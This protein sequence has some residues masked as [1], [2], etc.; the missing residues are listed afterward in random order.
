[1]ASY[2]K[3]L[4]TFGDDRKGYSYASNEQTEKILETTPVKASGATKSTPKATTKNTSKDTSIQ[5]ET[6][7]LARLYNYDTNSATQRLAGLRSKLASYKSSNV[8]AMAFGG[9][10]STIG[11]S[12][13]KLKGYQSEIDTLTKELN[14]AKAVQSQ[15]KAYEDEDRLSKYDITAAEKRLADMQK[16]YS[17]TAQTGTAA[18][19]SATKTAEDKKLKKQIEELSKEIEQARGVQYDKK[20]TYVLEGLKKSDR[21]AWSKVNRLASD[22]MAEENQALSTRKSRSEL[23]AMG[24]KD[25]DIDQL[26]DYRRRQIDKERYMQAV[27]RAQELANENGFLASAETVGMGVVSGLGALDI[28]EQNLAKDI[29]GDKTPINYYTGSMAVAAAR[30]AARGQVASNIYNNASNTTLGEV[31]SFLYQTGMSMA[32]SAVNMLTTSAVG[33]AAGAGSAAA[34]IAENLGLAIMGGSAAS[35]SIMAAKARGLSDHQ[36]LALGLI[37]GAAEI[38]TEKVS[39]EAFLDTA[40]RGNKSA[41]K[42]LCKNIIAEGS[43]EVA[44]DFINLFSDIIISRDKSEW[45]QSV[46]NYEDLGYDKNLAFSQAVSDQAK[47]MGVSFL[48]GALSGGVMGA[49]GLVIN[50]IQN[51]QLRVTLTAA[52]LADEDTRT[53]KLSQMVAEKLAEGDN[54]K[55]GQEQLENM[56]SALS[57]AMNQELSAQERSDLTKTAKSQIKAQKQF[58]KAAKQVSKSTKTSAEA[59]E[60]NTVTETETAAETVEAAEEQPTTVQTE[61]SEKSTKAKAAAKAKVEADPPLIVAAIKAPAGPNGAV[62]DKQ[63]NAIISSKA[64]VEALGLEYGTTKSLKGMNPAQSKK[65]VRNALKNYT[66]TETAAEA[67]AKAEG[68]NNATVDN[69]SEN[70]DNEEYENF[71]RRYRSQVNAE[72]TE[73]TIR[74]EYA[75]YKADTVAI[76]L[77]GEQIRYDE[78]ASRLREQD[79]EVSDAEVRK[80]FNAIVIDQTRNAEEVSTDAGR[81]SIHDGG[82]SGQHGVRSSEQNGRMGEGSKETKGTVGRRTAPDAKRRAQAESGR[83][84][85]P[86]ARGLAERKRNG[87]KQTVNTDDK[88]AARRE[89][90]KALNRVGTPVSRSMGNGTISYKRYANPK[91]KV[92]NGYSSLPKNAK[93]IYGKLKK[94]GYRMELAVSKIIFASKFGGKQEALGMQLLSENGVPTVVVRYDVAEKAA[95]HEYSH[96]LWKFVKG[97]KEKLLAYLDARSDA[98]RSEIDDGIRDNYED[99]YSSSI[100]GSFAGNEEAYYDE[101]FA[102]MAAGINNAELDEDMFNDMRSEL[103]R[104]REETENAYLAE[105]AEKAAKERESAPKE[106][107]DIYDRADYL[108]SLEQM[109]PPP[110]QG[111]Y[112]EEGTE[113]AAD[114]GENTDDRE[115]Y[116]NSLEQMEPP[117]ENDNARFWL[118]QDVSWAT[119]LRYT[120][121]NSYKAV[122]SFKHTP[123]LLQKVGLGD[124]TVTANLKHMKDCMTDRVESGLDLN[125]RHGISRDIM[126]RVPELL[127]KPAMI[128]ASSTDPGSLLVVLDVV[129]DIGEPVVVSIRPNQENTIDGRTVR[130]NFIS[131]VYGKGTLAPLREDNSKY[132]S[133]PDSLDDYRATVLVQSTSTKFYDAESDERTGGGVLYWNKD[134]TNHVLDLAKMVLPTGFEIEN[135]PDVALGYTTAAL[136][137]DE[138]DRTVIRRLETEPEL[139]SDE[140]RKARE[141]NAENDANARDELNRLKSQANSDVDVPDQTIGEKLFA[142]ETAIDRVLMGRPISNSVSIVMRSEEAIQEL[143]LSFTGKES[144]NEKRKAIKAALEKRIAAEKASANTDLTNSEP[145][146]NISLMANMEKDDLVF[147][148]KTRFTMTELR[149]QF[150]TWNQSKSIDKLADSVFRTAASFGVRARSQGETAKIGE[151]EPKG[152]SYGRYV[153]YRNSFF[154]DRSVSP[155]MK[156]NVLLHELIHTCTTYAVKAVDPAASTQERFRLSHLMTDRQIM[157][158]KNLLSI[159]NGLKKKGAFESL[160]YNVYNVYEFIAEFSSQKM[161]RLLKKESLWSKVRSKI[162]GILGL[163]QESTFSAASKELYYLLDHPNEDAFLNY[164]KNVDGIVDDLNGVYREVERFYV[165]PYIDSTQEENNA[166]TAGSTEVDGTYKGTP[167][168]LESEE[169]AQVPGAGDSIHGAGTEG[170]PGVAGQRIGAEGVYRPSASTESGERNTGTVNTKEAPNAGAS[171]VFGAENVRLMA[172]YIEG[173]DEEIDPTVGLV[174]SGAAPL[175]DMSPKNGMG[176]Y[177]K[178]GDNIRYVFEYPSGAVTLAKEIAAFWGFDEKSV[179]LEV[180]DFDDSFS[181][182][183]SQRDGSTVS[184]ISGDAF[185]YDADYDSGQV[186]LDMDSSDYV[187]KAIRINASEHAPTPSEYSA[188]YDAEKDVFLF[189]ADDWMSYADALGDFWESDESGRDNILPYTKVTTPDGVRYAVSSK[190]NFILRS[191]Q[192]NMGKSAGREANAETS[193]V[194]NWSDTATN[195]TSQGLSKPWGSNKPVVAFD[196]ETGAYSD[197]STG[198]NVYEH[199]GNYYYNEVPEPLR[200]VVP[201][202]TPDPEDV[203]SDRGNTNS[204]DSVA[205]VNRFNGKDKKSGVDSLKPTSTDT[206]AFRKWFNDPTEEKLLSSDVNTGE[207]TLLYSGS[208]YAGRTSFS[209]SERSASPRAAVWATSTRDATMDYT[210]IQAEGKEFKPATL[211]DWTMAKAFTKHDLGLDIKLKNGVYTIYAP[212][213]DGSKKPVAT[214]PDTEDG[215]AKYN[216]EYSDIMRYH[217]VING[218]VYTLYGTAKNALVVDCHNRD[219]E[220]CVFDPSVSGFLSTDDIVDRAFTLDYDCVIFKNVKDSHSIRGSMTD[221]VFRH[222]N[223]VKSIYNVGTWSED[224]DVRLMA[225]EDVNRAF[226]DIVERGRKLVSDPNSAY[227]KAVAAEASKNTPDDMDVWFIY[228]K[229]GDKYGTI[230]QTGSNN[231]RE[232]AAPARTK[233]GNKVSKTASTVMSAKAT[234]DERLATIAEAIVGDKLSYTPETDKIA[235][236]RARYSIKKN[237]FHESYIEW[238][239]EV[240]AGKVSKDLVALGAELLNNTGNEKAASGKEYVE[241]MTDY[242][243]LLRNA[244]QAVQAAKLLK[245]MTPESKLYSVM[246]QVDRLNE[247]LKSRG[248]D[249]TKHKEVE[250]DPELAD[251]YRRATTDEERNVIMEAIAQNIAGQIPSTFMD[252]FTAW[253]YLAMLG[254]FRTQVRNVV[255]NTV[256]QPVRMLKAS[257]A[258]LSEA[259]LNRM[260]G[261]KIGRTTS[262]LHDAETFKA[263]KAEYAYMADIILGGGKFDDSKRFS[264]DI[265][266]SRRIF[267]SSLLEGYRKATNWAM[268]TGDSVFCSFTYADALSRFIKANG[269]T[270]SEASEELK[271]RGRK[272]AIREAAEATYRD[273]NAFSDLILKIGIKNPTNG[274]Q[275]FGKILIEG[276]LPFKKTP[277]NILVRSIEYSPVGLVIGA[278][279]TVR[280]TAGNQD[281]TGTDIVN[282]LSKGLTGTGLLVLGFAASAM[283]LLVG[284]APDKD[285]EKELWEL[286]GHQ[287]YSFEVKGHSYT[288]DWLAP[289]SVPMFLGANLE[290]VML[291]KG[292]GLKEAIS[293]LTSI[294][295]PVLEMSM[296]QGIQDL[297]DNA[298]NYGDDGSLVRLTANTLWSYLTQTVPT[299]L[300][301]GER[302][303]EL[304]RMQT[305]TDENSNMPSDWQYMLGKLSAKVPEW[306]YAQTVYTDAWGRTEANA[307][308][309]TLNVIQQFFSPGYSNKIQE[310][311]MEKELARLYKSTGEVDV[312][313]SKPSKS[314]TYDG[315]EIH[316]TA[317]Q[318]LSYNTTRGQTAYAAVSD[319]VRREE[320]KSAS[321]TDKRKLVKDIYEFSTELGK[322]KALGSTYESDALVKIQGVLD[323]GVSLADYAIVKR[324]ANKH[325]GTNPRQDD[326]AE[327]L[328][329]MD[330][331]NAQ[332]SALWKSMNKGWV[333]NPYE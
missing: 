130:T 115:D 292:V 22:R 156:A 301:Q 243:A 125:H 82:L 320:Y 77:N 207:P 283:G 215:L 19:T 204:P 284:K 299:I 281:I 233:S 111:E 135:P 318:F 35:T 113:Y 162:R 133:Y 81:R 297:I 197:P 76:V 30:D 321:D 70:V 51:E 290:Q 255:G 155:Q 61:V 210:T 168:V 212:T 90:M 221:Y 69:R 10:G 127:E 220:N 53:Y 226:N 313:I 126:N 37:S 183:A 166:A 136:E 119:Q 244:G 40:M 142:L 88:L 150:D 140:R 32:D 104:I 1:M 148:E 333:T 116:L 157:A 78:F 269:T 46:K 231:A 38:V 75:R 141:V 85:S 274:A 57:E 312:L 327:T 102:F 112:D 294:S 43:E 23:K 93:E 180:D 199:K 203:E 179:R 184:I 242:A 235:V 72:A 272:I 288:L 276:A 267:K 165:T 237:G 33:A 83:T 248:F 128:L 42:E 211:T 228:N 160:D 138:S 100:G 185:D 95:P 99:Y 234:P 110:S 60:P 293:A 331:S 55:D 41:V 67:T 200:G 205:N 59:V 219:W 21:E 117:P 326:T 7:R 62:S 171:S 279:N 3:R 4:E 164:A 261:G 175:P 330:L 298:A 303:T 65:A 68:V 26:V 218:G 245:N 24:Y 329:G 257:V 246:R 20:G 154:N 132:R 131:S 222:G 280:K 325:G 273:N 151:A 18:T 230:P 44:A 314:F 176:F 139:T 87:Q 97:Y 12:K 286:Q 14:E 223:Q 147:G 134:R 15:V 94:M 217:K 271:D 252:K 232:V 34:S 291:E 107:E 45:A 260:S 275:K 300:G 36:A 50:N 6:D 54:S 310:S 108:D 307:D 124:L 259:M 189:D 216:S 58:D 169:G 98:V 153:Q 92:D 302:A 264:R 201:D 159:Y 103:L 278:V 319:L 316:L 198:R 322:G 178:I 66:L 158:A 208:K 187:Q 152:V 328:S 86:D 258:G 2:K 241:I 295:D 9:G 84:E 188:S 251:A 202:T 190:E 123:K 146:D 177:D 247:D 71:A 250:I 96:V 268:D 172:E 167:G 311:T 48:G 5:D 121:L 31:G 305:Y 11:S 224:R 47:Q 174:F 39:V 287:A 227:N 239:K 91:K 193:E 192:F 28:L 181:V 265:E 191:L 8:G 145:S 143:G 170:V 304:D 29:K 120:G 89:K 256:M 225:E 149:N 323:S 249:P 105:L 306:D 254:N 144:N 161:Q 73:E 137:K 206:D 270:W 101:F 240:R 74:D 277:A 163:Q 315:K 263:A 80:L 332:K 209:Q 324:G 317:D 122:A 49:G 194:D 114:T 296:L 253:R 186:Q 109:E 25:E 266:A 63:V 173:N 56:I 196:P 13:S 64:S 289:V 106:P 285:K 214:Y 118:R 79:P 309:A 195:Y 16:R 229:L 27:Q 182:F 213:K 52:S 238:A 308:N 236:N 262:V 17:S 282:Q 129:N